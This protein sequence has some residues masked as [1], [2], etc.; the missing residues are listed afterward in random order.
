MFLFFLLSFFFLGGWIGKWRIVFSVNCLIIA[1]INIFAIS[2]SQWQTH[3]HSRT[4][5]PPPSKYKQ[6]STKNIQYPII[7][8]FLSNPRCP[9]CPNCC[10]FSTARPLIKVTTDRA[11]L[12]HK[13]GSRT[14]AKQTAGNR[15]QDCPVRFECPNLCER[16]KINKKWFLLLGLFV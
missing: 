4:P 7:S 16:K 5:K 1:V 15:C 14:G 2:F 8:P 9:L 11:P 12:L 6:N 3:I 13:A 10:Y